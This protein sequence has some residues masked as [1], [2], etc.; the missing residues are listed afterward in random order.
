M[1]I[2]LGIGS[3]LFLKIAQ[4]TTVGNIMQLL[5]IDNMYNH[6]PTFLFKL[7]EMI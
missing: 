5:V 2:K 3:K 7:R 6:I 4:T 1:I